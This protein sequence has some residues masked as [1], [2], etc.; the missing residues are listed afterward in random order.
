MERIKNAPEA[1]S[2]PVGWKT[3]NE[4]QSKEIRENSVDERQFRR[5]ENRALRKKKK[6]QVQNNHPYD[7]KK[8]PP[9]VAVGSTAQLSSSV[10]S[11]N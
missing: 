3:V 9:A 2:S 1:Y 5:E 10:L 8:T 11:V 4:Y 6:K 7:T